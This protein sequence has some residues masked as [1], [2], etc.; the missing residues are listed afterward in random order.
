MLASQL[1]LLKE[2]PANKRL[3]INKVGG[4]W[5]M[6]AVGPSFCVHVYLPMNLRTY[7]NMNVSMHVHTHTQ[8]LGI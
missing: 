1:R 8:G 4:I 7:M 2:F 5:G 3:L 6:T